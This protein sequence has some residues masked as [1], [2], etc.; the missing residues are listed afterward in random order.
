MIAAD[1]VWMLDKIENQ[2]RQME[3]LP[4]DVGVLYSDALRI[5][6]NGNLLEEKFIEARRQFSR[7]PEGDLF[8]TLLQ[9][10][11]IPA[12]TTLIRRSCYDKVGTYDETLCYEDYDMWLRIAQHYR[13]AFSPIISAKYRI[14]STSLTNTVLH[15]RN[16][17][18]LRSDFRLFSKCLASSDS[19]KAQR[20]AIQ[21][22]LAEIGE[23]MYKIRCRGRSLILLKTVKFD[24]RP[25]TLG[26]FAFSICG[27]PY[28]TFVNFVSRRMIKVAP[29]EH[30][31]TLKPPS[32]TLHKPRQ[33]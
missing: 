25:F 9:K 21:D 12:M 30:T 11:F 33:S 8:A 15:S 14:V 4:D 31:L 1:D 26:M 13:F 29:T 27:L 5:D 22:H 24:P 19:A 3:Q 23:Q 18:K 6:E 20:R 16:C 7:M 10:N 28:Q 32:N 17:L 2:V